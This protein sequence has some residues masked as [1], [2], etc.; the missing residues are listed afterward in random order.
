[1]REL[2]LVFGASTAATSAVLGMFRGGLGLG[3]A[4]LGSWVDPTGNRLSSTRSWNWVW[5]V[6]S[7]NTLFVALGRWAHLTYGGLLSL[8]LVAP[9]LLR[10]LLS[11]ASSPCRPPD[12]WDP[13]GGGRAAGPDED[14]ARRNLAFLYG[15]NTLGAV[16]GAFVST[17][18]MLETFGTR[19]TLWLACIVNALIALTARRM[20]RSL[21]SRSTAA[22]TITPV[23]VDSGSTGTV[24]PSFVYLAAGV[25]GF[26]FLLMEIVWYRM[27]AAILGGTTYTFGLVLMVALLGIGIGGA[28]YSFGRGAVRPTVSLFA[29]TCAL[30]ALLIGLPFAFGDSIAVAAGLQQRW[31]AHGFQF[32]VMSWMSMAAVVILP[33]ALVAGFQFPLLIGLLGTGRTDVGRHVGTAYAW[34]TV[35]AIVGSIAG[36]FL[37]LPIL[38][39]PGCWRLVIALLSVLAAAGAVFSMRQPKRVPTLVTT[40]VLCTAALVTLASAGPSAVWRHSEIGSRRA[41]L[42][43]LDQNGLKQWTNSMQRTL[44]WEA[45]GQ[46]MSV[47]LRAMDSLSF[48]VNGKN[49]GNARRDASTQVGSG[50]ISA[51]LHP[52]PRDALVIGLGTGSTAGWLARVATMERVDAVE[53][54]PA[55]LEVARR[56]G[57]VDAGL[58]TNPVANIVLAD[59]RE[60]LLTNQQEYDLIVSE[61][62][63]PYRAGIA[64]LYT[65]E[66]YRAVFARLRPG[67]FFTQWVQA[68]EI[69]TQTVR[70]IVATLG[71]VFPFVQVWQTNGV[72]IML[73]VPSQ[74]QGPLKW[75][76][77]DCASPKIRFGKP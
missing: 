34:N 32:L 17:F 69:D 23:V 62:S 58:L 47:G 57:A 56:C 15:A 65:T 22:N 3:G 2:R 75:P 68:Y 11:V 72:D 7:D 8:G 60:V 41:Q 49:D 71:T 61:P 25:V 31:V 16:L 45:E 24:A 20:S 64:S 36:G 55:V 5:P 38:T 74:T 9:T 70:T 51:A 54:E 1:M 35:G 27:L 59:G 53:L 44:V 29:L 39:A 26:A 30:E 52:E 42:Q 77:S 19:N 18:W 13:P 66:F 43:G 63:N 46:E 21:P 33:S 10:L 50:M 48:Y 76:G 28:L 40:A 73:S 37:L 4:I 14:L 6:R 67:G 12:G